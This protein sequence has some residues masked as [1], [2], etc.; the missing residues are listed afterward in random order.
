MSSGMQ[1]TRISW[2]V[3][4]LLRAVDR[5]S[6]RATARAGEAVLGA[7]DRRVPYRTGALAA[8][9]SVEVTDEGT[10]V[11]YGTEYARVLHA[12]PEWNYGGRSGRWLSEA[13]DE[14]ATD[15]GGLMAGELRSGWPG[16]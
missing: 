1:I 15:V 4:P 7:A 3:G 10:A 5:A 6:E 13:V 9:G 14:T 8:S 12:H 11:S 16:G 2:D